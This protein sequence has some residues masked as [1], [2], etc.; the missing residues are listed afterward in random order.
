LQ[1][2]AIVS[3]I[4][5]QNKFIALIAFNAIFATIAIIAII[6]IDAVKYLQLFP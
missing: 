5:P 3:N 6:A 1:Y 2:I 4:F